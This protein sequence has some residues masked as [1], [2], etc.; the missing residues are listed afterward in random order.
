MS[1]SSLVYFRIFILVRNYLCAWNRIHLSNLKK[2]RNLLG[3][4]KEPRRVEDR[5][6]SGSWNFKWTGVVC[7]RIFS[8]CCLV[9]TSLY[10]WLLW[11]H[12]EWLFRPLWVHACSFFN[13]SFFLFFL[14]SITFLFILKEKLARASPTHINMHSA[15]LF[16]KAM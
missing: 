7:P 2:W 10:S 14:K 9:S 3:R 16:S 12:E 5:R 15:I 8:V 4:F 1:N 6:T 11:L 13:L